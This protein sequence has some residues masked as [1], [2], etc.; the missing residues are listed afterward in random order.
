MYFFPLHVV[1]IIII[2]IINVQPLCQLDLWRVFAGG[3]LVY[4]FLAEGSCC[5]WVQRSQSDA[6]HILCGH[7]PRI[8]RAPSSTCPTGV[9]GCLGSEGRRLWA[10]WGGIHG[11]LWASVCG[12]LVLVW[13]HYGRGFS[14]T[15]R[16]LPEEE[17]EEG[18]AAATVAVSREPRV[19]RR[20][21]GFRRAALSTRR[22]GR[23]TPDTRT[24]CRSGWGTCSA[25]SA[26]TGTGGPRGGSTRTGASW[27]PGSCPVT[28]WP[29]L[30]PS[31]CNRESCDL[32]FLTLT[33]LVHSRSADQQIS[34]LLILRFTAC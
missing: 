14:A 2:I 9:A 8:P 11:H 4:C 33:S 31:K 13:K 27:T 25:S 1:I 12:K 34:L 28:T 15:R 7:I 23:L 29:G 22:S 19:R 21:R 32:L 18:A 10:G 17:E 6:Q 24:S 16:L 20:R 3:V 30:S 26:A 5:Q